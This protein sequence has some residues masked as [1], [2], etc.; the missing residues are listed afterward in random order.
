MIMA[1]KP[2]GALEDRWMV[3]YTRALSGDAAYAP[4]TRRE[5]LGDFSRELFQAEFRRLKE[6]LEMCGMIDVVIERV[7]GGG[8]GVGLWVV[9]CGG[10]YFWSVLEGEVQA[11]VE[12]VFRNVES[13]LS[14]RTMGVCWGRWNSVVVR[15]VEDGVLGGVVQC[16]KADERTSHVWCMPCVGAGIGA[17]V[18][19]LLE[20]EGLRQAWEGVDVVARAVR[21]SAGGSQWDLIRECQRKCYGDRR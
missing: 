18:R 2:F 21:E 17:L 14:H 3:D 15:D 9:A 7:R 13:M 20:M 1:A 5:V 4:P 10:V 6:K 12:G 16:L 11:V 19:E 8:G